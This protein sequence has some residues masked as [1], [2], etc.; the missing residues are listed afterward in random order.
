MRLSRHG[1][2]EMGLGTVLLGGLA[3][4]LAWWTPWAGLLVLPVWL[5]LLAFFRDPERAIPGER[6]ALVSPADGHVSDV[7]EIAH[8]PLLDGPAVR[9]GIFLSI[10]DVHVN[11]APCDGVVVSTER[12]PGLFLSAL[13]HEEAST[14]NESNTIVLAGED[15]QPIAVVRQITGLIARRIVCTVAAEQRVTRGQRIGLIKFGSRTELILPARL[16]PRV[17]VQP[18]QRVRGG[19]DIVARVAAASPAEVAST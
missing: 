16:A 1:L 15:G 2:A 11:R 9:V 3:A 17:C 19:A 14:K 5:W 6:G 8:E 18:G 12:R 10:F 4:L 13:R 7:T